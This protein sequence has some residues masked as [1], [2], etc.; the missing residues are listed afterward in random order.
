MNIQYNLMILVGIFRAHHFHVF[1]SS[2]KNTQNDI[3]D[4]LNI[5]NLKI[6]FVADL[7]TYGSQ[8]PPPHE[9]PLYT[10]PVCAS[11]STSLSLHQYKP[12]RTSLSVHVYLSLH[13]A[14]IIIIII[15]INDHTHI[16]WNL[17]NSHNNVSF[18]NDHLSWMCC[19]PEGSGSGRRDHFR[20]FYN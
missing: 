10:H 15:I 18:Y 9:F 2:A 8:F 1:I 11:I 5:I 16:I 19:L 13:S 7:A 4:L 6:L 3:D 20:S 12:N 17:L 14:H